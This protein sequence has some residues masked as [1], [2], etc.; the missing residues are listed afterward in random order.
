[1][2]TRKH[3]NIVCSLAFLITI[4]S[5]DREI[6][7]EAVFATAPT[8]PFVFRDAPIGLTDEFF[9]SFDPAEG[10]N[11]E[12]FGVDENEFFEGTTSIRIDVP[13]S[14]DPNGGFIGGIFRD[15]G[16]GRDLSSYDALTFWAKG[17]TTGTIGEVGFG[18]DFMGDKF[19]VSR[20]NIQLTTGWKKYIVPIPD[21]SKLT[22]EKGMFLFAA[23][24]LDILGDG[25]N[26]NEIGWTFW[27]DE[28]QFENL[29]TNRQVEAQMLNGQDETLASFK[30]TRFALNGFTQRVNLGTGETVALKVSP[31]YFDYAFSDATVA[32]VNNGLEVIIDGASGSTEVTAS[33]NN[34]MA[35]G[36]LN[37]TS[38]GALPLA[39]TPVP[40]QDNVKS[41]YSDFYTAITAIN[42]D[43]RFVGSS[44]QVSEFTQS[45][46]AVSNGDDSVL[47]YANNNFT[48]ILFNSNIDVSDL[49]FMNIDIYVTNARNSI[50]IQ[51]RD[52]GANGQINTNIFTGQPEQDDVDF[53]FTASGLKANSWNTIAIPLAGNLTNQKD[54]LGAIILTGGPNFILDNIYF[55]KN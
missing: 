12:G 40:N 48:G 7:D 11:T 1:M 49:D 51:I 3:I 22:Q 15:R 46:D 21:A 55:Y 29:G 4:F 24:G 10:A 54:N 6:T 32:S 16:Q 36:S 42:F 37:V 43:P 33:L 35:T 41:L 50:G 39:N 34:Q 14:N 52:V 44:T 38:T 9:I 17:S 45:S 18:T 23:G 27:I 31:A 19:P 13:A 5:C 26:G 30:G 2:K 8:T 25:P 28:I 53:R 47:V 20:A